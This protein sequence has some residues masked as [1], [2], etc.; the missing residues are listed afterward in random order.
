MATNDQMK[1][2][3]KPLSRRLFLAG[4]VSAA[5]TVGVASSSSAQEPGSA[6][7]VPAILRRQVSDGRLIDVSPIGESRLVRVEIDPDSERTS[8][9]FDIGAKIG[10][11]LTPDAGYPETGKWG[12]DGPVRS[13]GVITQCGPAVAE[14]AA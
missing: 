10:I 9:G 5:A 4:G 7:A 2:H 3:C 8:E 13:L 6:Y 11:V 12:L 1:P 14:R